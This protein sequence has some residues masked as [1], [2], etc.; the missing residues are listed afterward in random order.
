MRSNRLIFA[1]FSA[2][3]LFS[4]AREWSAPVACLR[5]IFLPSSAAPRQ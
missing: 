5:T 1:L 2:A 3:I 4:M